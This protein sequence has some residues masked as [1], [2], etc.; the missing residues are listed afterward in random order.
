MLAVTDLI[1]AIKKGAVLRAKSPAAKIVRWTSFG[2][3]ASHA[4]KT[5]TSPT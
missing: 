5:M 1:T 3:K 4:F 2:T